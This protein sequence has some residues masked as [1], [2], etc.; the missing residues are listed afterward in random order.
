MKLF[1]LHLFDGREDRDHGIVDPDIDG[2]ELLFDALGGIFH[3]LCVGDIGGQHQ[4]LSSGALHFAACA[5]Q[6]VASPGYESDSG[7]VTRELAHSGAS[8]PGGRAGDHYD[9]RLKHDD[10]LMNGKTMNRPSINWMLR[11]DLD[12]C[13]LAPEIARISRG[14]I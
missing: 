5:F 13:S 14:E 7:S 11:A 1:R 10:F 9:F 8:H 6:S 12:V 4:S 2:A 3:L